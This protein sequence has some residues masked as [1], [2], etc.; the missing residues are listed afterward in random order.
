MRSE[1]CQLGLTLLEPLMNVAWTQVTCQCRPFRYTF[2]MVAF[3]VF[4][5]YML[6]GP[7]A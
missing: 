3:G 1:T 6:Y 5:I 4:I 7:L 2:I